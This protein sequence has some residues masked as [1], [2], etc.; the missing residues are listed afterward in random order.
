MILAIAVFW[1]VFVVY[2][3]MN[4]DVLDNNSNY[5]AA[6]IDKIN[7]LE[8]APSGKIILIGGS[9]LAFGVNSEEIQLSTNRH[10]VN[11]GLHAGTGL[12]ITFKLV[13]KHLQK[14]DI[15]LC[16]PEYE[17]FYKDRFYGDSYLIDTIYYIPEQASLLLDVHQ[18]YS[19]IENNIYRNNNVRKRL[20]DK[21]IF[22]SYNNK[23]IKDVYFREGFNKYGDVVS[24][25][26]KPNR[27]FKMPKKA[28]NYDEFFIDKL[29]E[30]KKHVESKGAKFVFAYPCISKSQY[31]FDKIR[32]NSIHKLL[33]KSNI[34][35]NISPND[36]VFDDN[37][38]FD[39]NYHLNAICRERRTEVLV[40]LLK[41]NSQI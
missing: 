10:V 25:L 18:I 5:L 7:A 14:G 21:Y 3:D 6:I 8:E 20:F 19:I 28:G 27:E 13:D 38:F 39:T 22:H 1:Y 16:S 30:Y 33:I 40:N 11:L 12:N 32:V 17:Y 35:K 36:F 41:T 26:D 9:N 37:C 15:V 23:F 34:S 24:H 2:N 31:D 4:H 29:I